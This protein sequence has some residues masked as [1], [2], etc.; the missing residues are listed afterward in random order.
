MQHPTNSTPDIELLVARRARH[1]A[2]QRLLADID[3]NYGRRSLV[4]AMRH[5]AVA[6]AV[7]AVLTVG[8]IACTSVPD[9]RDMN[10]A[11]DRTTVLDNVN[12]VIEN[13]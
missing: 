4:S 2:E 1:A 3:E 11:T 10:C 8:V 7:A 6:L 12:Y 5:Y 9:G 13:L